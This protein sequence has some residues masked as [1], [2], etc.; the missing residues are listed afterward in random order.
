M[1]TDKKRNKILN[2]KPANN[3]GN[4][5]DIVISRISGKG[6]F[7]FAKH[8][9]KWYGTKMSENPAF[10]AKKQQPKE[11]KHLT[12]H[13]SHT[14]GDKIIFPD[15]SKIHQSRETIV[16]ADDDVLVFDL[17]DSTNSPAVN[18]LKILGN[19][20][21][22]INLLFHPDA[23]EDASDYAS[24]Y[25]GDGGG[26]T[27]QASGSLKLDS[28]GDVVQID[29][30]V[31]GDDDYDKF[32][33]LDGLNVKFRTGAEVLSDIG[34]GTPLTTEQVQDI[35]GGMF[36]GNTETR[37]AATYEDGD[38][39][40]D[41]ENTKADFDIDH[42]FTLVGAAADTSE[43][44]GTFTG[45]TISDDRTIK[46]ALQDLETEVE[47]KGVG[48]VTGSSTTTFTNKTIDADGTG[49]SISN[50]DI[51][52][53]TAAVVVLESEGITSND[54]DTTLPTSAAVKD[55][56][57]DAKKSV[58][59]HMVWGGILPRN[60]LA[61]GYH[62]CVP[63]A[64]DSTM[65][66]A[67]NS[68]APATSI[69]LANNADHILNRV[70]MFHEAVTVK[71]CTMM[72]AEGGTNASGHVLHLMRYTVSA[73]GA[74]SFGTVV[75]SATDTDS[76]DYA[77]ANRTTLTNSSTGADLNVSTSQCL[78]ATIESPDA[79]NTYLSCKVFLQ[80]QEQTS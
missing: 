5:G 25:V 71:A 4:N 73:T 34:A 9:N 58:G 61:A 18:Y 11:S 10:S 30:V 46:Q 23:K 2:R 36:T 37:I 63:T 57:D 48:D 52:N 33:V 19:S 7:L 31:A 16:S 51:G 65:I 77:E 50:I 41:L 66:H 22:A 64:Y 21:H 8:N 40:I 44:L 28:V 68:A 49:N 39:N 79:T 14:I 72:Y 60:L 17:K 47:T 69:S 27:I 20:G 13:G 55:H 15:R 1:P 80:Y 78:V 26:V 29:G 35:V 6:M 54:N 74:L 43:N 75:A 76:V 3:E 59:R 12:T 70:I 62:M 67:G 53:M 32:L 42:L 38:N 56:V 45:G 24:F